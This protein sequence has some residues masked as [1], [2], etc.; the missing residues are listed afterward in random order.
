[1]EILFALGVDS[2]IGIQF[3]IFLMV[4]VILVGLLFQPYFQAYNVR[5]ERTVGNTEAAERLLLEAQKLESEYEIKAKEINQ[6][7]KVI[8]D[9][10]RSQAVAECDQLINQARERA[11]EL[12][13]TT[14]NK[15]HA[16]MTAAQQELR[17]EVPAVARV[18]SVQLIGKDLSL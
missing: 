15:I 2:S 16:D 10:A 4:Y 7:F 1:M 8:Y 13:A 5:K 9:Q 17:R 18:V 14:K 6:R 3:V 12:V 11:R